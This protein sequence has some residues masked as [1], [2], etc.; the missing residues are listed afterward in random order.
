MNIIFPSTLPVPHRQF[1][2]HLQDAIPHDDRI[3][4]VAAAGSFVTGLMDEFSDLDLVVVTAPE[5]QNEVMRDRYTIAEKLGTLLSAFTG[6]HVGEP[7]LLICLYDQPLLHVDLKFV[8]LSDAHVRIENPVVLWER[9]SKLTAVIATGDG[10]FPELN[11]QWI[12]ARFWIWMHYGAGKIGRGELFEAIDLIAYI[13]STVLGPLA[14]RRAGARPQGVRK[15][16]MYDS[17][18]ANQLR[19]TVSSYDAADCLRAL[20]TCAELYRELRETIAGC[21]WNKAAEVATNAYLDEIERLV[22]TRHSS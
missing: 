5:K 13:R 14:L 22:Q 10:H 2:S 3:V 8:W 21:V 4:G 15:I 20:R 9:E 12:E 19:G 17:A 7:R 18:F 11:I 6:E 16:E 1:I